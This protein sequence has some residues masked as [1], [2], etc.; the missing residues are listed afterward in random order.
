MLEAYS[1]AWTEIDYDAIAHNVNEIQKLVGKTKIM[2]IVKANAYGLGDIAC[3]RA[4]RDCGID[5]FGVSS[6]DEALHLREAGIEES[7]LIL[8]YTPSEHFHYL[9]EQNIIQSLISIEYAHELNTYAKE[10]G[11]TIRCHCKVDTG[12]CRTGIIYQ[13]NDK[14]MDDIVEEYKM[15]NLHVEGIFSHFAVSDSLDKDCMDFTS[16]QI[17]LFD[18]VVENLKNLGIDCGIRHI[19]NSYGILNYPELEYEYCR[20]GLLYMGVTSDDSIEIK[21][22]P[23]FIPIMSLYANVSLVKW[24]QPEATVSY[25]RHFKADKP[26]KVATMSIGYADGLPRILSN[27]GFEV[28]VHGQKC[29]IIGNLCM[30]QCMIDVTNIEDVKEGDVVCIVGKQGGACATVDEI[31]RTAKTIN[32]ETLCAIATRVPRLKVR[33]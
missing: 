32:N 4:L 33:K 10:Q 7:I 16:K 26:T 31:S 6:V 11:I 13:E 14:H 21:T 18:E 19:Q 29:P 20:P 2:G 25:G 1:R 8:G 9:H 3:A 30:D 17:K 12:M 22:N 27:T 23:D 28:L 24:I 5:F 15:E